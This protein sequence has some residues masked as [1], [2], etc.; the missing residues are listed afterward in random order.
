M[1][2]KKEKKDVVVKEKVIK[3]KSKPKKQGYNS[4]W[5]N[6]GGRKIK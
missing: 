4:P 5:G 3:E 6:P 1:D 2:I